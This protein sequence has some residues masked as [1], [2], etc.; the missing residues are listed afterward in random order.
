MEKKLAEKGTAKPPV[1]ASAGP[2]A[3]SEGNHSVEDNTPLSK[4]KSLGQM[5]DSELSELENGDAEATLVNIE[6]ELPDVKDLM[7]SVSKRRAGGGAMR[8]AARRSKR[9]RSEA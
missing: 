7:G 1:E 9:V 6:E 4:S 8:D 3:S 5:S 2:E